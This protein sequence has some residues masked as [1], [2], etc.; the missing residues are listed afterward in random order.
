MSVCFSRP[1][2]AIRALKKRLSG[3][4]NYREVMLALT[5]SAALLWWETGEPY[6]YAL[7]TLTGSSLCPHGTACKLLWASAAGVLQNF[8]ITQ[9]LRFP[10]V[11]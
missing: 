4:R 7:A 6:A 2:D 9:S 10:A 8:L 5:V 3:N 1:K 11:L